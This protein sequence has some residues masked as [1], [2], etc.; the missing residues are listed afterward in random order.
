MTGRRGVAVP[1]EAGPARGQPDQPRGAGEWGSHPGGE[2]GILYDMP[3]CRQSALKHTADP[4]FS[5]KKPEFTAWTRDA[6]YY[7]QGVGFLSVFV[8]HPPQYIP[9]GELDTENL[10]LVDRGYS[11]ES[12]HI[13][14]LAWNFLP[15][16]LRS[17]SDKSI[18]H[19]CTSPREARDALLAWCAP[20]T[21]GGKPDLSRRLDSFK[22]A[23]GSSYLEEMG[24]I[25]N[26]A[27]EKRTAGMNLED[28]SF[29]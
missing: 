26:L 19:R 29:H 17:K 6:R 25:D 7:A 28:Y 16:A 20:Q 5:G 13:Y 8:S 9:A 21:T 4:S 27:A 22:I 2:L 12:A 11:R 1:V 10:A 15:T 3:L 18:L 24:R 14:A 23:P